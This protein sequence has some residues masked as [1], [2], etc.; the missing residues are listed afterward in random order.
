[1]PFALAG[2]KRSRECLWLSL[3]SG[4]PFHDQDILFDVSKRLRSSNTREEGVEGIAR[5]EK[6]N[7]DSKEAASPKH[8]TEA[9][10]AERHW[11]D[12]RLPGVSCCLSKARREH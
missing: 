6:G 11:L 4:G 8:W 1:M 9:S 7:V 3:R 12:R 2:L 5:E 10:A